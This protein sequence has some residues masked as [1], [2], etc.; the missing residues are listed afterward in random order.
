MFDFAQAR[1]NM[2]DN[3][4][5]PNGITDSRILDAMQAV[6][7][8]DFVPQAQRSLAYMDG[9]V[10]L[11]G[12]IS[13]CLIEPMAFAKM[14]Q[15]A[16]IT[17]GA[18]VLQIGAGTGYGSAVLAQLAGHVVAL[19]SDTQLLGLARANLIGVVNVSLTEGLLAAG[20]ANSGPFDAILIEGRVEHVPE[21]LFLQLKNG[22]RLVAAIGDRDMA[23]CCV[24]TADGRN[25]TQKFA[26]DISIATLPSFGKPKPGFAF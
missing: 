25:Y 1:I 19:E 16:G 6:I 9:D 21:P 10:V 17:A 7:R 2:V 24:W 12:S 14:V 13:R 11:D 18:E 15:L 23:K 20:A 3:Q 22:G 5:R 8:E 26:F 4:L